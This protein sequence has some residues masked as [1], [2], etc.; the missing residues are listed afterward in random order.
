[1]GKLD[2]KTVVVTG[3]SRG[4]GA[5]I[6][7]LF[8]S[9]G[10]RVVCAARTLHEG[11]HQLEGSLETT[12]GAIRDAG[13]EATAVT[14]DVS[15]PEDCEKL[16]AAAHEAYGP[17]DVMVNNAALTY[18]I[19]VKDYPLNRWLR[20]WAVNFHAPFILSQL[21]LKD[22]LPRRSGSIVNISSGAAIG[23]GR[24][25][26]ANV[27]P[28]SGGTCY[29]AEKAALERFT[30]GLAQ[31]VYADGVSVTCVSPS[32]VVPTPGT[33]FHHLV[34]GMDDPRGEPVHLMA[35]AALLLATEPL[36]KVSGRVTYSQQILAEFG[37]LPVEQAKGTG[38]PGQR[39]GSGYSEI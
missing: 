32:Q 33:V 11:D 6:A 27:P 4:I 18:F 3:A 24:G 7:R 19:P 30:Q 20:S 12:V 39:R 28:N 37:W 36:D 17:V 2:G 35:Q 9:E 8:A 26:Y 34:E 13:G 25:P 1:M 16:I 31:E 14:A 21:V 23:P 5:E 29:G 22:M 15:L 38:L 10:G